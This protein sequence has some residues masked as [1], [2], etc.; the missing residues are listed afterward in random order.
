[1]ASPRLAA[2]CRRATRRAAGGSGLTALAGDLRSLRV[3]TRGACTMQVN[4][5]QFDDDFGGTD[6]VP[7]THAAR[8][9]DVFPS[10]SKRP[11]T[12]PNQAC[13][14]FCV[15][16]PLARNCPFTGRH[17]GSLPND[18]HLRATHRKNV[19]TRTHESLQQDE[20]AYRV[21]LCKLVIRRE[22]PAFPRPSPGIDGRSP[23]RRAFFMTPSE[24]MDDLGLQAAVNL[25][26]F[27]EFDTLVVGDCLH[28]TSKRMRA[29]MMPIPAVQVLPSDTRRS[30]V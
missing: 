21:N 24:G 1:M 10:G 25:G 26:V 7:R 22:A 12:P 16:G 23:L 17:G 18:S 6:D 20:T 11:N 4:N 14:G 8:I 5:V 2:T 13:P 3:T 19:T 27:G 30:L 29:A 28:A 15:T 9:Y